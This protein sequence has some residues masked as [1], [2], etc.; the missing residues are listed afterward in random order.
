MKPPKNTLNLLWLI[1]LT[2][3]LLILGFLKAPAQ[4]TTPATEPLPVDT[5]Q[6]SSTETVSSV[7]SVTILTSPATQGTAKDASVANVA[8]E[9][10][11]LTSLDSVGAPNI[12]DA[13]SIPPTAR[14]GTAE[15]ASQFSQPKQ[16]TE[17]NAQNVGSGEAATT[18]AMPTTDLQPQSPAPAPVPLVPGE[19]RI[20][21]PTVD[22]VLDVPA[23]TVILQYAEG[24]QVELRVNGELVSAELVGRTETDTA[25]HVVTQTLYGVA[26]KDGTNTL[27]A[28]TSVNGATGTMTSVEVQVRGAFKQMTLEAVEARIPADGRSLATLQGQL[29]DEQ[30]NR[31]N[32]DAIVTLVSSA[33]TFDGAD[34]DPD[35]PGFQVQARQGQF[36]AALRSGL[37][38]KN[39]NVRATTANLE[40]FAQLQFETS[41]RPS[42]A[43]GVIDIRLGRRGTN[44]YG[45]LRDFLPEDGDYG[46]DLDVKAAVFATGKIGEWL[47]T[48]A[49]N[50]ARPLNQTCD[51][52]TRL[53]R[54]T[55]FCDQTYP[56]YG[57]SSQS[58]IMTP[59]IDHWFLRFERNS[60]VVGAGIDYAMWGD[61]DTQE[62]ARR[63][64]E[65]TATTRQL[66]GFKAN[67]NLGN[68]QITG[69]YANNVEGFQRDT[70]APDG[71]SGYYFLSRRLLIEGSENVF[72]ELEEL[73]RPGT[74]IDRQQLSRGPDYE[75]D[76]DR[77]TLLFRQPIL[78]TDVGENGETL[79]RR[80]VVTYQYDQPGSDNHI[81]AGR[82][83]YHLSRKL[84]RESWLGATYLQ[85]KLGSRDFELYG[86]DAYISLGDKGRLIAEYAHSSNDSVELGEV[87]GSAYRVELEGEIAKGVN[88]RAYY[89]A[90]DTG[91]ANNATISFV[92]GQTRYGAQVTAKLSST[93]SLRAQYDH[94]DNKGVAP[95]VLTTFQ[96]LFDPRTNAVPGTQVDNSLTTI[97]LGLQQKI[98]SADL[99]VDWLHRQREDRLNPSTLNSTSDQLRSR[100]TIPLAKNLTFLAQ[101]ETTLSAHV[102]P[103]YSDRTLLGLNWEAMP[104]INVQ[105]AQQFFTRGQYSGQSITSL[106]VTGDYKLGSDTT[107]HGRYLL[108]GGANEMTMQGA[109]GLNQR[110]RLAP[111]LRMD[112][113]YEHV[114]GNFLGRNAAATP[115]AQP[116]AAGQSA[117][118]LG[119]QSGDNFSASIEYTDNPDFQASARFEHR[120]SS[121]GNNTVISA[122]ATG[123]ITPS[124]TAL[125]RYRQA[126]AA[127]QKL[128]GLGD[129][130][131]LKLGLAYRNPK[132]DRF[133]ALLRYEYRKNPDTIPDTTLFGSG[134]GSKAHLLALE[135]IYAPNWRWEFYGKFALRN[136]TS[137]LARDYVGSSTTYLTQA[138]ATYRLGKQWDLV[139][140]ARWINQSATNFSEFGGVIEAG[141]Y[142]TPNLRLSAGYAL[143]R[144]NDRDF[145]G[146]RSAGGAYVGLTIKVNEL[147]NGFG[148]QKV[149]PAQQQ[150]PQ[151][152]PFSRVQPADKQAT[153]EIVPAILGTTIPRATET[154]L[155]PAQYVIRNMDAAPKAEPVVPGTAATSAEL[156]LVQ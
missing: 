88:G 148:L 128:T 111:G 54:D 55:Q 79:V 4:A 86:A 71:T 140:E 91:F 12:V 94:E 22:A 77:G 87:S 50:S 99:A 13:S 43:T 69:L 96:D 108:L 154:S 31:S 70:I 145:D 110:I 17:Q 32:R 93:T 66:H 62:F 1:P 6:A 144:V 113:S 24:S 19:V 106:G 26:L 30:G 45:S 34:V 103:V 147:F 143:G 80:I 72:V 81:L 132:D 56:V 120:S 28:Q 2:A 3:E 137:Y 114:F 101:N 59:S 18:P 63:S 10:T 37:E 46:T 14:G 125:V 152:Q 57:D 136:S 150:E 51:G 105:L 25:N 40:A 116:F 48:G 53:F 135:A 7:N 139:A 23:A 133:N 138:R 16:L 65:F 131:E 27:T 44:F 95:R 58:A 61:Y 134:T 155:V 123:K 92:P 52:D 42:I 151:A 47:F 39:V 20:L 107:I 15:D 126:S 149:S 121:S 49:Y 78:R 98:G 141:Y 64:Q 36:S 67:Y 146:S 76:Y 21:T 11:D 118:A 156:L 100:L 124:L 38:A 75:I 119:L 115:F 9:A 84:N 89:R 102:D 85:E 83:Q 73:N 122:G 29:L 74:V 60:P 130:A 33:G 41:L 142:L 35:Q 90:A 129:T 8:A 117:S 104:G 5:A 97:S 82:L 68:L 153:P 109:I 127:N 112:L